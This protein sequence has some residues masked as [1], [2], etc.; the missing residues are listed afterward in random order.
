MK[1]DNDTIYKFLH[2]L[3]KDIN[4]EGLLEI[5]ATNK[6]GS[7][8][9]ANLF[10]LNQIEQATDYAVAQNSEEY[11]NIYFGVALR[12][13]E[14]NRYKRSS[15]KD[16]LECHH[17]F[18][19]LDDD[20][21]VEN[22]KGIYTAKDLMPPLSCATGT[23]PHLR[24]QT[25]WFLEEPIINKDSFK[26]YNSVIASTLGGDPS[27]TNISRLMRVAGSV[28]WGIKE[29]RQHE[30]TQLNYF[31]ERH[32]VITPDEI[33]KKFENPS[34]S[35]IISTLNPIT[36]TVN[37][38]K[39]LQ[40]VK[41]GAWH[42]N[43]RD[44]VASMVSRQYTDDEI[45][46]Y[47]K[48]YCNEGENDP[49]L[50]KLINSARE[51]F[52]VPE[53]AIDQLIELDD[54]I[55]ET[56]S[57]PVRAKELNLAQVPEREWLMQDWIPS[58][59]VTSLYGDGGVGKTLL[60]QQLAI[61]VATK[62]KFAG[63]EVEHGKVLGLFCEDDIDELH[64]RQAKLEG[65]F[66]TL[67]LR[68]GIENFYLWARVG[69]DNLLVNYIMGR[70]QK[71]D[72]Y[73]RLNQVVSKIKPKLLILDT[74]SDLFGGNE[75]D[76]SQVNYFVKYVLG[77]FCVNHGVT[78]LLLAHPSQTGKNSGTGEAG[79]TAWN[80]AVRSRLYL[81]KNK[82]GEEFERVL[83]RKK[84]NYAT[85]SDEDK[86]DFFFVNGALLTS[87]ELPQEYVHLA[88]NEL[89]ANRIEEIID[90]AEQQQRGFQF[91]YSGN[92]LLN[93]VMEHLKVHYEKVSRKR[94]EN[95]LTGLFNDGRIRKKNTRGKRWIG[96]VK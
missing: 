39:T 29:G 90:I 70:P 78:V 32:R 26:K 58:Q 51:K 43:M 22:A 67:P 64:I 88:D 37:I 57:E 30:L 20:G 91:G 41:D 50:L 34:Q 31:P 36:N 8:V 38:E 74:A 5:S 63:L 66:E 12:N 49:D 87:A 7:P 56:E 75:I 52:N 69:F 10:D 55:Y 89:L 95:I 86:L 45:K 81:Q 4:S 85:A 82:D 21:A 6:K 62:R 60:A 13:A 79:S 24:G 25:Y 72:F 84:A 53:S 71:T 3:Y 93:G 48:N 35:N 65:Y 42:T 18:L 33:I 14:A 92:T 73:E 15:D 61:A 59:S 9:L 68:I 23:I 1:P 47:L 77:S 83:T 76:R 94:V 17:L 54:D 2:T 11:V 27:I 40:N 44:I 19:D 46:K 28:A 80:N 96:V 16:V